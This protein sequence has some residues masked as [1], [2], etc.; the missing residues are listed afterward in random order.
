MQ[1][2]SVYCIQ[3]HS[4]LQVQCVVAQIS[5]AFTYMLPLASQKLPLLRPVRARS[6]FSLHCLVLHAKNGSTEA[7]VVATPHLVLLKLVLPSWLSAPKL[8][9]SSGTCVKLLILIL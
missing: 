5:F 3:E 4:A 9:P 2:C 7:R 1:P 8:K 6:P